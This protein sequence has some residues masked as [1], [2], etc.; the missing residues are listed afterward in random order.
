MSVLQALSLSSF[1]RVS[2][3]LFQRWLPPSLQLLRPH[4]RMK[5]YTGTERMDA[6]DGVGSNLDRNTEHAHATALHR[7][8]RR[9]A[10]R[11]F[12]RNARCMCTRRCVA[13]ECAHCS[14]ISN[15]H[16]GSL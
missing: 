12:G 13:R 14:A 8:L 11:A 15:M 9:C 6:D 16:I 4:F 5:L 3:S 1:R 10:P 2:L 7:R